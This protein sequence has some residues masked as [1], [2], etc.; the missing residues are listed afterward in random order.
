MDQRL[1]GLERPDLRPKGAGSIR[2]GLRA[3]LRGAFAQDLAHAG[4]YRA[5][6][7]SPATQHAPPRFDILRFN[8]QNREPK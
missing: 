2:V 4:A 5:W 6:R 8:L 3:L 1:E 7:P